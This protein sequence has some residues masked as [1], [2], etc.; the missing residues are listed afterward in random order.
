MLFVVRCLFRKETLYKDSGLLYKIKINYE[1]HGK[2]NNP[3]WTST[4]QCTLLLEDSVKIGDVTSKKLACWKSLCLA[5]ESVASLLSGALEKGSSSSV[6]PSKCSLLPALTSQHILFDPSH[7][8][9]TGDYFARACFGSN[10]AGRVPHRCWKK[11]RQSGIYT[12]VRNI[13]VCC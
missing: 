9:C 13:C 5:D 2:S 4:R 3:T 8:T 12:V 10:P 6:S 7:S 1:W 11:A